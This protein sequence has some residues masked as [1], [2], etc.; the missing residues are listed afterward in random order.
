[1]PATIGNELICS[2]RYSRWFLWTTNINLTSRSWTDD[3]I[4]NPSKSIRLRQTCRY[5]VRSSPQFWWFHFEEWPFQTSFRLFEHKCEWVE[6]V[7]KTITLF[8][9]GNHEIHSG[10]MWFFL[11][12]PAMNGYSLN[13]PW[14]KIPHHR[15]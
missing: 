6:C 12:K 10:T 1:M 13:F 3:G 11:E 9:S 2:Y 5:F 4:C 15:N 7:F 14:K 8:L